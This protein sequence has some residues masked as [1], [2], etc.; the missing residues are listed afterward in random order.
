[1]KVSMATSFHLL[2]NT[3]CVKEKTRQSIT[4]LDILV[5]RRYAPLPTWIVAEFCRKRWGGESLLFCVLRQTR[6]SIRWDGRRFLEKGS[7]RMLGSKRGCRRWTLVRTRTGND[8]KGKEF[9]KKWIYFYLF[10]ILFHCLG[11]I[12][13]KDRRE[14]RKTKALFS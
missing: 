4:F 13:R 8:S 10:R 12:W 5:S 9:Q 6:W 7:E 14:K 3:L 1:M 11:N 2:L